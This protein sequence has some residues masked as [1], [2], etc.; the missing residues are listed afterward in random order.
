MAI[1]TGRNQPGGEKSSAQAS[2]QELVTRQ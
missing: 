2:E 1:K